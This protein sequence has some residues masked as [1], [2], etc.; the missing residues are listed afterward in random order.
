M[1]LTGF[2]HD[3]QAKSR[4]SLFAKAN[5]WLKKG[6]SYGSRDSWARIPDPY[7]DVVI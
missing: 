1:V 2:L 7:F 6:L 4:S 3:S 5:K